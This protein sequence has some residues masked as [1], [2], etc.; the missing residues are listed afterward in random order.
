M[1]HVPFHPLPSPPARVPFHR[2]KGAIAP[3]P[4]HP[5]A[6]RR[7]SRR[8]SGTS[9]A[10]WNRSVP[11]PPP[12][13]TNWTGL[14]HPSVLTGHVSFLAAPA[15]R[16]RARPPRRLLPRKGTLRAALRRAVPSEAGMPRHNPPL[17]SFPAPS[18][19][20]LPLPRAAGAPTAGRGRG[21]GRAQGHALVDSHDAIVRRYFPALF[22]SQA[23]PAAGAPPSS[24]CCPYPCPYWIAGRGAPRLAC[25]LLSWRAPPAAG[26]A[27]G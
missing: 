3:P 4:P 16:R 9:R 18:T 23:G 20:S 11:S 22:D 14:V 26:P 12:S 6:G 13:R 25:M 7:S 19:P 5:R 24:Y 8:G 10:C 2:C 1:C 15:G 27:C 17:S 21:R